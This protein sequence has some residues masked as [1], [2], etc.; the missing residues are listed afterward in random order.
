MNII[1]RTGLPG[2]A[3][4]VDRKLLTGFAVRTFR[5]FQVVCLGREVPEDPMKAGKLVPVPLYTDMYTAVAKA[6]DAAA[7]AGG[8]A[9]VCGSPNVGATLCDWLQSAGAKLVGC[10]A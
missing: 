5:D 1:K 10:A 6:S 2:A 9:F 7:T 4:A 8:W 3:Y